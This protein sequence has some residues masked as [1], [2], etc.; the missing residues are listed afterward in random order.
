MDQAQ[1]NWTFHRVEPGSG[2]VRSGFVTSRKL[3]SI[4]SDF[5]QI[6][7]YTL[8]INVFR[9]TGMTEVVAVVVRSDEFLHKIGYSFKQKQIKRK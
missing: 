7:N 6:S 8:H 3:L 4:G 9:S 2:R 1:V 5:V